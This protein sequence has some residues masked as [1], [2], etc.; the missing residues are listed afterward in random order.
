M[1]RAPMTPQVRAGAQTACDLYKQVVN[2][3]T[4]QCHPR[5]HPFWGH[6]HPCDSVNR[7]WGASLIQEGAWGRHPELDTGGR[8]NLSARTS[9][10]GQEG[11]HLPTAA[12]PDTDFVPS[13]GHSL[14]TPPIPTDPPPAS[15]RLHMCGHAHSGHAEQATQRWERALF[16]QRNPFPLVSSRCFSGRSKD[17]VTQKCTCPEG[18]G[19]QRGPSPLALQGWPPKPRL[20]MCG[21][22]SPH[23]YLRLS[24]NSTDAEDSGES[25]GATG[26]KHQAGV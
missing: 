9:L 13:A 17:T 4:R 14:E 12:Q 24:R 23:S 21:I 7:T 26:E 6:S 19:A 2:F 11:P 25:G 20:G 5:G 22:S 3:L 16:L 1:P 18:C 10:T 15:P 8:S